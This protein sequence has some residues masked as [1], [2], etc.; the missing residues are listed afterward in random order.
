MLSKPQVFEQSMFLFKMGGAG[1]EGSLCSFFRSHSK[2]D[3]ISRLGQM[4]EIFRL[5]KKVD[6]SIWPYDRAALHV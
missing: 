5:N 1:R 3:Y 6:M 2:C 4:Q